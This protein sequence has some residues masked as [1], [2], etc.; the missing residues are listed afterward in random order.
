MCHAEGASHAF[1]L[2]GYLDHY[3]IYL[4]TAANLNA[5]TLAYS[6]IVN[7]SWDEKV[8]LGGYLNYQIHPISSP[9]FGHK[10]AYYV[11]EGFNTY[12][13]EDLGL[14]RH[15]L[16]EN[17]DTVYQE[18][19]RKLKFAPCNDSFIVRFTDSGGR[20]GHGPTKESIVIA[21]MD[22]ITDGL[23][24]YVNWKQMMELRNYGFSDTEYRNHFNQLD[25]RINIK[26]GTIYGFHASYNNGRRAA[27]AQTRR[28]LIDKIIKKFPRVKNCM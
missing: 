16:R 14:T 18:L 3:N 1:K 5:P 7:D 23:E 10:V 12:L 9:A 8:T 6:T 2:D 17:T 20:A 27:T 21:I 4:G 22:K 24:R 19:L 11:M 15:S 25:S 28:D 13:S 26:E